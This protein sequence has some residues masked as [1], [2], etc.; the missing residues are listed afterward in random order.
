MNPSL[1]KVLYIREA[2]QA[3][4]I[5]PHLAAEYRAVLSGEY[6]YQCGLLEVILTRKPAIWNEL[7]KNFK[8]DTACERAYQQTSDGQDEQVI[9][10]RLKSYEKM[11]GALSSLIRIAEQEARNIM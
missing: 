6:A 2:L 4:S 1:D 9:K 11:M 10:L 7:R 5:P 8:S 3:G